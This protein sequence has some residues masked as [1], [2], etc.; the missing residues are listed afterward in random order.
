MRGIIIVVI[1]LAMLVP[2]MQ[3]ALA[4]NEAKPLMLALNPQPE[5]PGKS[6]SAKQTKVKPGEKVKT[7]KPA[8]KVQYL[9]AAPSNNL[10]VHSTEPMLV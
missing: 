4:A 8:E 5:P 6:K 2:S 3:T 9:R 10:P 1:A 7:K